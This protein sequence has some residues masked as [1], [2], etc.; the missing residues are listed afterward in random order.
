LR[1]WKQFPSAQDYSADDS[2]PVQWRRLDLECR[3]RPDRTQSINYTL[4]DTACRASLTMGRAA[5]DGPGRTA[6]AHPRVPSRSS[7]ST[8]A[9]ISPATECHTAALGRVH[10]S[11][12]VA[13]SV[14]A[15]AD[16]VLPA[17]H[18]DPETVVYERTDRATLCR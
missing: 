7:S 6:V 16:A 13:R 15:A 10:K 11:H 2:R 1:V 4:S 3:R 18:S 9:F 17:T 12:R 5:V 8:A 14:A